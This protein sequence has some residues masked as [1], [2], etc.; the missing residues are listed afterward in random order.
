MRLIG[1]STGALAKGDF[2][3]GLQLQVGNCT[4]VELSALRE[5]EIDPLIEALPTLDL[6]S[7][8]FV[9]IHAPSKRV[10]LSERELIE[11]LESIEDY[12]QGIVV[13]PDIIEDVSLWQSLG[14]K[15]TLENMDQRKLTGRTAE[16][17]QPYFEALP[18]ARFCLDLGHAQQVDPTQAL[19][20]ELLKKFASR[21]TEIHISEVDAFGNH[22][23]ISA[24]AWAAFRCVASLIPPEVPVII[25]SVV[26]ANEI[27]VEIAIVKELI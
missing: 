15:V 26:A 4:A 1:F 16:E 7:F 3:S 12:V 20:V 14:E 18:K 23:A 21:L 13:H 8:E 6:S 19:T 9:S 22:V 24:S 5:D 27:E 25:E 11:K 2:Y 10:K 17:L